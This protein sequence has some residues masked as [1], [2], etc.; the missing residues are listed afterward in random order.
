LILFISDKLKIKKFRSDCTGNN[1][2]KKREGKMGIG[3][4]SDFDA[5]KAVPANGRTKEDY[6]ALSGDFFEIKRIVQIWGG[7]GHRSPQDTRALSV[8]ALRDVKDKLDLNVIKTPEGRAYLKQLEKMFEA[9]GVGAAQLYAPSMDLLD[10]DTLLVIDLFK[11]ERMTVGS[12]KEWTL[13]YFA[14]SL[15]LLAAQ[16]EPG[17]SPFSPTEKMMVDG[18]LNGFAAEASNHEPRNHLLSPPPSA[19]PRP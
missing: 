13:T 5:A 19:M 15:D 16:G 6:K 17:I 7:G 3:L 10:P 14:E 11:D 18:I 1:V 2:Y 9:T 4:R 8:N 12:D